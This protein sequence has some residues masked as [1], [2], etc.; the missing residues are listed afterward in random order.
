[1]TT[2]PKNRRWVCPTCG[3]GVLAPSQPRRDDVRRFCL[4]CSE[5]TGRLVARSCPTL[6]RERNRRTEARRTKAQRQRATETAKRTATETAKRE[7]IEARWFVEGHDIRVEFRRLARFTRVWSNI[8]GKRTPVAWWKRWS[9]T[10]TARQRSNSHGTCYIWE[11]RI[12]LTIMPGLTWARVRAT[13]LHEMT[14]AVMPDDEHHGHRFRFGFADAAHGVGY[15]PRDHPI[16]CMT[17]STWSADGV[18]ER[19]LSKDD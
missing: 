8:R 15:V 7:R 9:L 17:G 11:R 18:V 16:P 13:L 6:D 19:A 2:K 1:M 3:G 14:H 10:T 4:A 5:S 12:N